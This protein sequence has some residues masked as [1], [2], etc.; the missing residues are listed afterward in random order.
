[1]DGSNQW[2]LFPVRSM[3]AALPNLDCEFNGMGTWRM[4]VLAAVCWWHQTSATSWDGLKVEGTAGGCGLRWYLLVP[5][6]DCQSLPLFQS[7]P[8]LRSL[9]TPQTSVIITKFALQ[10]RPV[11]RYSDR[12]SHH[13][14]QVHRPQA[15]ARGHELIL[16]TARRSQRMRPSCSVAPW[17]FSGQGRRISPILAQRPGPSSP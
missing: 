17:I 1:M 5:G 14:S 9:P 11:M 7:C 10:P 6:L 2:A 12:R 16:A 8:R 15:T 4:P 13:Q 3:G